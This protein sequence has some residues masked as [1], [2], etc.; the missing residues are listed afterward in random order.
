MATSKP[1]TKS[2]KV[3]ALLV[4]GNGSSINE[5]GKATNWKPHSIRAF[6]TGLR[7][8]SYLV[9][10]EQHRDDETVYRIAEQSEARA[11]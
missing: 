2:A 8:R 11:S 1:K 10:R 6:L 3:I 4:R 7:K 5:I 9:V